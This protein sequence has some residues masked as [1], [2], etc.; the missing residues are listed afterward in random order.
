ML[1]TLGTAIYISRPTICVWPNYTP[2]E[3]LWL[4]QAF[5]INQW[6]TPHQPFGLVFQRFRECTASNNEIKTMEAAPDPP[7]RPDPPGPPGLGLF[8]GLQMYYTG[9]DCC[10]WRR[11]KWV[12]GSIFEEWN[13]PMRFH[14]EQPGKRSV[15]FLKYISVSRYSFRKE[16]EQF[17]QSGSIYYSWLWQRRR[18]VLLINICLVLCWYLSV[19]SLSY[20]ILNVLNSTRLLHRQRQ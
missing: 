8:L 10:P 19:C 15:F 18:K 11:P 2:N 16:G 1:Y 5:F 7:G 20:L 17:L 4:I 14:T 12:W 6:S 9:D 3:W 13:N